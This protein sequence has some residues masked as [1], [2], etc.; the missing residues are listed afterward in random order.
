MGALGCEDSSGGLRSIMAACLICSREASPSALAKY[1]TRPLGVV[2]RIS[3]Y[4]LQETSVFGQYE[5][6]RGSTAHGARVGESEHPRSLVRS[7]RLSREQALF[8]PR[9][10]WP[11]RR[12]MRPSKG[13]RIDVSRHQRAREAL[14]PSGS[15]QRSCE[16]HGLFNDVLD[17]HAVTHLQGCWEGSNERRH[18]ST[19]ENRDLLARLV[20]G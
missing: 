9:V 2:A 18:D 20:L 17:S 4:T 7:G 1:S 16:L 12:R 3:C 15:G 8:I 14:L 5:R 10:V 13:Q 6:P 11:Q 19:R